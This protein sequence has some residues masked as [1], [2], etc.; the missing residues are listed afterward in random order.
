M[1]RYEVKPDLKLLG[2]KFG[3]KL[4]D[5]KEALAKCDAQS[6]AEKVAEGKQVTLEVAGETVTLEANEVLVNKQSKGGYAVSDDRDFLVALDTKLTPE[7]L[8][9]GM[10]RDLVRLIQEMRKKANFQVADRI[11]VEYQSDSQSLRDAV[12]RFAAYIQQETLATT[13]GQ[14][15][16]QGELQQECKIGSEKITIAIARTK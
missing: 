1:Y 9:E 15:S 16:G 4:N 2:K 8:A 3:K 12:G 14:G 11:A 10:A 5:L 6:V 13:L 7:L